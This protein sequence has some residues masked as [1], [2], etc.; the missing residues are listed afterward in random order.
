M[1]RHLP[2][3]AL[4]VSSSAI[5]AS[6]LLPQPQEYKETGGSYAGT[7][8][9]VIAIDSTLPKEGY[10]LTITP[11]GVRIMAADAAGAFWAKQ[12]LG[13]LQ[14]VQDGRPTLPCVEIKDWP[15]FAWRGF[16]LDVSRHFFTVDE[17]KRVLDVMAA[18]KLNVFH[19]HLTDGSGWRVQIDRYPELTGKGATRGSQVKRTHRFTRDVTD[20]GNGKYGPYFYTKEQIREVIA[21][22]AERQIRVMP[23]IEIPGHSD[24][25]IRAYPKLSCMGYGCELCIGNDD[26]IKFYENVLD[27][28]CELFPDK[29]VHIGGDECN[30][31]NWAKCPKCQTL[32]RQLGLKDEHALQ[33]WITRHFADYL[34]RKGK[35]ILGWDE[36]AQADLPKS[37]AVMKWRSIG[38]ADEAAA[39]GHD[40]VLTS[41]SRAYV[42]YSQGLVGDNHEYPSFAGHLTIRDIYGLDPYAGMPEAIRSHLLGGEGAAWTEVT[43]SLKELEWKSWPRMS[44]LAE[45]FWRNEPPKDRKPDAFMVRLA[46]HRERLVAQGVNAA[47]LGPNV[48]RY[49]E[50][51]EG[52]KVLWGG[53]T[54]PLLC[55]TVTAKTPGIATELVSSLGAGAYDISSDW[56]TITV[57]YGDDAALA[58]AMKMLD[59]IALPREAGVKAIPQITYSFRPPTV[60]YFASDGDDVRDGLTPQTAWRTLAKIPSVP[61]GCE[62]RLKC[63]DVFFGTAKLNPGPD[64]DRPTVLT[65]WGEGA[66]PEICAYKIA[67]GDPAVWQEKGGNL[68]SIDLADFSKVT[69]NTMT[70]DGNV[71]FLKV[72]GK[73]FGHKVFKTDKLTAQWDFHEDGRT[74]TVWSVKNP[75]LMTKDLRIAVNGAV[76][77]LVNNTVVRGVTISGTGG[78]GSCGIGAH[79]SILDCDYREIGGSTLRGFGDGMTRYGNGIECWAGSTDIQVRRCSISD[80]Y[81]VAFTMQGGSPPRSWEQVHMTDCLIERC[82][83]AYELWATDCK[84]GIGLRNCSFQRNRVVDTAYGW[85]YE[86][87]PD[88]VN[89]TP[90]LMYNMDAE[91][92][93]VLVKGNV[94]VNTRGLLI[95]KSGGQSLLPAMYRVVDNVVVGPKDKTLSHCVGGKFAAAEQVR[96]KEIRDANAFK[97]TE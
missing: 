11:T 29:F 1:L 8:A 50:V 36:I 54:C 40:I 91:V 45:V 46:A 16:L 38:K 75:A 88:K 64:I 92:C 90:L 12:T 87:R 83:Q 19:W 14:T 95:F 63:G 28:V 33:Y 44:V 85:A 57:R 80:V 72:D 79:V 86:V 59:R 77:P 68:W 73:I 41:S 93:D 32:K 34:A 94:F 81:D 53:G 5:A 21:Y 49:V 4:F 24:A 20:S 39:R 48:P 15:A 43:A 26:T 25:A 70:A 55:E 35:R 96:N 31:E 42:D 17:V 10:R 13:Q 61:A 76:V 65:S 60:R 3:I 82:S 78:H 51:A 58:A 9:P 23:E 18:H 6:V 89:A 2:L 27:E 22:A 52:V 56:R 84:P 37:A 71:G 74:A 47:P 97:E 62:A 69:G 30:T 67:K 66:K 7:A